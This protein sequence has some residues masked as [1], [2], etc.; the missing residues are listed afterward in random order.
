MTVYVDDMRAPF[1]RLILCHMIADTAEE[2]HSMAEAIGVARRWYQGDHYD[3]SLA[4]RAHAVALGAR[5]ITWRDIGL[6]M[7]DRH[8]DPTGTAPLLTPEEA[9]ARIRAQAA[10]GR[11]PGNIAA[12]AR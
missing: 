11:Q 12:P 1:G 2:L 8:R 3:V 5:E 4:K 6:M 7:L 10:A 9:L